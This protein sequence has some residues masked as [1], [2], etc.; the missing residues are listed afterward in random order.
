M[1]INSRMKE[2]ESHLKVTEIE[3]RFSDLSM[4][5]SHIPYNANTNFD[6]ENMGKTSIESRNIFVLIEPHRQ[7]LYESKL[8]RVTTIAREHLYSFF[9]FNDILLYASGAENGL[10]LRCVL[11]INDGIFHVIDIPYHEN[12][13]YGNKSFEIHSAVKSFVVIADELYIKQ[14]WINIFE[15][16]NLVLMDNAVQKHKNGNRNVIE[17]NDN[18][19]ENGS[20]SA[21]QIIDTKSAVV[22]KYPNN[23]SKCCQMQY[24]KSSFSFINR[25]HHCKKCGLL[26]CGNCGKYEL[27]S[28][29]NSQMVIVKP[30]CKICFDKLAR[31]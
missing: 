15:E 6:P 8:L 30:V 25:R 31:K 28:K 5:M 12:S 17:N 9:L 13:K 11:P 4:D 24:C 10:Q 22:L 18:K 26:I 29:Y 16:L 3:K 7:F 27:L 20:E 14:A 21:E 2:N 1:N 19:E 23:Y